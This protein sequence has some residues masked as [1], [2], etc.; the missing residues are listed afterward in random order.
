MWLEGGSAVDA[1]YRSIVA[2]VTVGS[3]DLVPTTDAAKLFT[4]AYILLGIGI[5]A[6]FASELTNDRRA[7]VAERLA[8]HRPPEDQPPDGGPEA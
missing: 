5:L 3:G 2:L 6:A 1:R 7:A 4:V 8:A